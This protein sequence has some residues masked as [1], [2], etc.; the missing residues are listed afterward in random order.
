MKTIDTVSNSAHEADAK[1]ADATSQAVDAL[2]DIR[3]ATNKCRAK[4]VEKLPRLY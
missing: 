1:I 3:R 4:I 2:G